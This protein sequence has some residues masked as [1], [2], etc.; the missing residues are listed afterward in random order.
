M[1]VDGR[2]YSVTFDRVAV[3]AAQDLFEISPAANKACRLYG[4]KLGQSSDYGDT[5]DEGLT[6]RIKRVPTT[7]TSGSGGSA[8]TPR[9]VAATSQAAGFTAETNN[10][11]PA[12]SSGTIELLDLDVFVV[13][14][15]TL[16]LPPERMGF[17]FVNGTLAIVDLPVG[18]ADALTM[19]GTLYVIEQG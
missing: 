6:I 19:S 18:P 14:A 2:I 15:G 10:T 3:S 16:W 5:Q 7:A 13:R 9:T 4:L 1:T 17:E 8:P 11:T 12:T